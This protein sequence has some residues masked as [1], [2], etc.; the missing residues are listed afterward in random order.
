MFYYLSVIL[1]K[2]KSDDTNERYSSQQQA[3]FNKL[4]AKFYNSFSSTNKTNVSKTT[5]QPPQQQQ[6][7]QKQTTSTSSTTN[8]NSKRRLAD[9]DSNSSSYVKHRFIK[10]NRSFKFV[11]HFYSHHNG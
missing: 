2:L 5:S 7:Q 6:Q 9:V 8:T 1:K 3:N 10:N 11:N 4:L